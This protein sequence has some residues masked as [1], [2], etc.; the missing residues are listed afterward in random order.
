MNQ[1]SF[2]QYD[3]DRTYHQEPSTQQLIYKKNNDHSDPLA[4]ERLT[5]ESYITPEMQWE[6][7]SILDQDFATINRFT[8]DMQGI[9]SI[10]DL[11]AVIYQKLQS[12]INAEQ[13]ETLKN[14]LRTML[15]ATEIALFVANAEAA[16]KDPRFILYQT[17]NSQLLASLNSQKQNLQ[18]VL[19]TINGIQVGEQSSYFSWIW[20]SSDTTNTT[21]E[22]I[23][24]SRITV[25]I[26]PQSPTVTIPAELMASIIKNNDYKQMQ[27][28]IQAANL[29]FKQC[30]IAQQHHLKDLYRIGK[31]RINLQSPVSAHNYIYTNFPDFYNICQIAKNLVPGNQ[32]R[33]DLQSMPSPEQQQAHLL[34]QHA[35][36]AIQTAVYIAN[37]KSDINLGYLLPQFIKS[38][39]DAILN[40]LLE[41]DAQI[42]ALCKDAKLGATLDDIYQ[43][44]Q[45]TNL[46]KWAAGAVVA[47]AV[48]AGAIYVNP[49]NV[50]GYVPSAF[51]YASQKGSD[52]MNWWNGSS[53]PTTPPTQGPAQEP[54]TTTENP[55]WY[56]YVPSL[57]TIGKTGTTVAMVGNVG[58]GIGATLKQQGGDLAEI[59]QQLQY[60]GQQAGT[61]G[62]IAGG[63]TGNLGNVGTAIGT[64]SRFVPGQAG[65]VG[66]AVGAT[67]GASGAIYDAYDKGGAG[68]SAISALAS[69]NSAINAIT[70]AQK[71]LTNADPNHNNLDIKILTPQEIYN[72]FISIIQKAVTQGGDLLGQL[73][74]FIGY[75]FKNR[76]ANPPLLEDMLQKLPQELVQQPGVAE[77]VNE[78]I[79]KLHQASALTQLNAQAA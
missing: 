61:A 47:T 15:E 10:D 64:A 26:D 78:L 23:V 69:S 71:A 49:T 59:G 55:S 22:P 16:Q 70:N 43:E 24:D 60:Y 58:A 51:G 27:N 54:A 2:S 72:I 44:Q 77:P 39:L 62:A 28:P 57:S 19:K 45:Q 17:V 65:A 8:G 9:L 40:Q 1:Y 20:G 46:T 73:N 32:Y 34:L 52:L 33:T 41:Y 75:L 74:Q 56:A 50:L 4:A 5:L 13:K 79:N 53:T 14:G 36:Q 21:K 11:L 30:F 63:L 66:A 37:K 12:P 6:I 42:N 76:M 25:T 38:R 48:T 18:S 35:R 68:T 3:Y 7:L 29:L 31:I 67:I